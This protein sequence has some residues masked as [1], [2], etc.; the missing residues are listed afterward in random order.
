MVLNGLIQKT[1]HAIKESLQPLRKRQSDKSLFLMRMTIE[2]G[3]S[4]ATF[5]AGDTI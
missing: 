3:V 5:S 1:K 4:L 2:F